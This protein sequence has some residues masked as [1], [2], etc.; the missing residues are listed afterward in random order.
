VLDLTDHQ[1]STIGTWVTVA[2]LLWMVGEHYLPKLWRRPMTAREMMAPRPGLLGGLWENRTLVVAIVGLAIVAWLHF[3]EVAAPVAPVVVGLTEQQ[4]NERVVT[5]TKPL[6]GKL[7]QANAENETLRQNV[8][9]LTDAL[10]KATAQP[11]A[12]SD[13]PVSVDKL[14][15]SLQ[16]HFKDNDIEEVSSRN[17][18]W[19]KAIS[20]H[21]RTGLLASQTYPGWLIVIVF[22]KPIA[23][24]G[25]HYDDHGA[26]LTG[27]A[28]PTKISSNSRFAVIDLESIYLNG[29]LLDITFDN[30][31]RAK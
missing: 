5:A 4:A 12:Q 20:G 10:A 19:T 9:Q 21:V 16:L 29:L 28:E 18:L 31:E 30:N 7:D 8:K 24:K 11:T 15:T 26:G 1:L 6:Q 14:P 2:M 3:R 25:V 22:K 23:F 17:I 13:A 27:I